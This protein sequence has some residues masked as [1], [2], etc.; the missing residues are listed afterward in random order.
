MTNE[1]AIKDIITLESHEKTAK[2]YYEKYGVYLDFSQFLL[3]FQNPEKQF[4]PEQLNS[5]ESRQLQRTIHSQFQSLYGTLLSE[6]NFLIGDKDI[7]I[8]QLQRYINIPPHSHNFTECIFVLNGYCDHIVENQV[9]RHHQGNVSIIVPNVKHHL[10]P[11]PDCL[12]LTIKIR[13]RSFNTMDFPHLPH[14]VYPISF[15]TGQDSFIFN[16][17]LTIYSQQIDKPPCAERLMLLLFQSI[18]IYICQNYWET[19]QYLTPHNMQNNQIVEI[20]NYIYQNY[21]S[22]TLVSLAAHF[23]FNPAY[24]S[25][26]IKQQTGTSFTGILRD[27]RLKHAVR[28]LTQSNMPVNHICTE[29][30]YQDVS[31]FI[32]N[33]RKTYGLTPIQ[34][35]KEYNKKMQ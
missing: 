30:G 20:T 35:R 24:L 33:F 2:A 4:T 23:H 17:L 6:E 31:Q 29:V 8:E 14:L 19:M 15:Q 3:L 10:L 21:Q 11:S 12:C 32:S 34:Y 18:M 22:V 9:Y 16:S 26:M 25:T 5:P 28:L 1:E 27:I 7:E 13:N